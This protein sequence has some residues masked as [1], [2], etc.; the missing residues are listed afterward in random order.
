M[1]LVEV[2]GLPIS[3]ETSVDLAFCILRNRSYYYFDE[4][5]FIL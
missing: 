1:L 2:A 5:L 3:R 4:I